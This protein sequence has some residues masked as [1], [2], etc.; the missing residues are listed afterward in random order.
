MSALRCALLAVPL[1]MPVGLPGQD[2]ISPASPPAGDISPFRRG[3]W[4][5]Q[6]SGGSSFT[7]LGALRFTTSTA[8][9]LFDARIDA[10]HGNSRITVTT[11]SGDTTVESFNSLAN[12]TLRIGRRAYASRGD[13][14]LTFYTLGVSGG[15]SHNAGGQFGGPGGESNGWN[16]GVFAEFGGSYLLTPRFSLGGLGTLAVN[17]SRSATRSTSSYRSRDWSYRVSAPGLV[18]V[19][20]LYF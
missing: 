19:A 17:Y 1:W 10:G 11:A 18:F 5:L 2:S 12:V 6:F 3:Q 9:W 13:R 15:F 7:G 8:A 14:V 4:A 16:A 20:T